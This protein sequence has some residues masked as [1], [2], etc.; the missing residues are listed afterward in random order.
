MK[1]LW[2]NIILMS[3]ILLSLSTSV[4][5]KNDILVIKINDII[6]PVSSEFII[7]NIQLANRQGCSAIIIELDTPGGLETSMRSIVKEINQSVIPVIVYV[8]PSGARAGS[9]GVFITMAAHV[10]AMANGTNIGAAH[11]V[12]AGGEKMDK[13]MNEKIT[14]DSA[15]FIK[16][17]ATNRGRNEKWA[18]DAVR[19]SVSITEKDAL[20]NKVID[21][22][23]NNMDDLLKQLN[24]R[25][26]TVNDKKIILITKDAKI[27]KE[28]MG[29]RYKILSIISNPSVAYILMLLGFYGLYFEFTSP[30]AIF[31]GVMGSICIILAFYAFQTLPV[32]MAGVLLIIVGIILFIL[33]VTILSHGILTIGG[34][35]AMFI[36]SLML[37]PASEPFYK[38]SLGVIIP[39]IFITALFFILT[40]RLAFTAWKKK[41]VTGIES[42][43]GK[44]A[45]A[46]TDINKDGTIM[47]HGELW[48]AWSDEDIQKGQ[49]IIIEQI[50]GLKVKVRAEHL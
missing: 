19:N 42:M 15:A 20:S 24:N 39:A 47:I 1:N 34:I 41:P 45:V 27:I 10:A 44:A 23:A 26:I 33:E 25:E 38:I 13:T 46:K 35:I 37:I 12:N 50:Q 22:I 16:S 43:I 4:Y 8:S 40:F 36:G 21:I 5:A 6:S 49:H 3:A 14:N 48:S 7:E 30:G 32:N 29:I 31:P 11:P 17:I 28:E 18:E 9:A 2:L